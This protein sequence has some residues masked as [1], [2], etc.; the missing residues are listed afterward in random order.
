MA[1]NEKKYASIS[2]LQS[3]LDNIKLKFAALVHTH[4]LSDITDY[5]VD[6]ELSSTS[7]NPVQNKAIDAEFEAVSTAMEALESVV[8]SKLDATTASST[9][10]TKTDANA[11]KEAL[12]TTL[13]GKADSEHT[14]A[15]SDVTD[16]QSTLD[17]KANS[18]HNHSAANITSGTLSSDRLPTVPITKGGTGATTAAGA[19]TNLGLTATASELNIMDGVTATTTELNYVDGV[20]SNIQTQLN[21]KQATINGGATTITDSNLTANRALISNGS[22]KVAVSAVTSTELGYLDGVTSGIQAQLDGKANSSTTLAGY[23][24]TDVYTKTEVDTA[25]ANNTPTNSRNT[26][27]ATCPTAAA[28]AAKVVTTSSGDFTLEAGNVVYIQFTYQA[29]ANAT[30]NVDGTGAVTI[31]TVGTN[32]TAAYYWSPKETV[33][34]VYDGTYFRMID[35]QVATTTYYGMTKLSSSTSSTATNVAATPSAVKAAYDRS[36]TLLN[37]ST[38]VNEADT[39]YTTIMARGS[40]L[41]STE[42]TP[43]VNGAVAW[44]YE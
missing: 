7:T 36:A 40:S 5:K 37:R 22:G 2:S 14:H 43:D 11:K 19:L 38:A 28:T 15:I 23:G 8:D 39:N 16:L 17:G 25:I 35:S 9:Y 24:I 3:F 41:N 34:F 4:K 31:Q 18:S 33:G 32:K 1:T 29:V 44:T 21:G 6:T 26:W 13:N 12:E 10:E 27:Y 30:L 20:T 42:A